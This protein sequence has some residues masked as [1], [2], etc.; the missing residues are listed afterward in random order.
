MDVR[1]ELHDAA[2]TARQA[3]RRAAPWVEALARFGYAA[4]GVVYI[5]VG[6][7]AARAALGDGDAQGSRGALASLRDEPFGQAMLWLIGLGLLGY[8]V[9]RAVAA[10]RNPENDG[11]GK[12][13]FHAVSALAYAA[14]AV[15][16]LRVASDSGGGGD[17]NWTATLM[18]APFGRFLV[19]VAG[20]LIAGYGIQQLWRAWTVD[21]DDRLDL[22]RMSAAWRVPVVRLGR[23]G[24]AARGV[25]F[26]LLGYLIV[27]SAADADPADAN[28]VEG[29]LDS[30]RDRPWLLGVVAL[31]LAAYGV[32]SLVLA[33]YRR[34]RTA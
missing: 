8:V 25:V 34:I 30:M 18:E 14:L 17:P 5:L 11:A 26:G 6:G 33:R 23:A 15:G 31:G 7:I 19:A 28:G 3:E 9:W 12:R 16:T 29:V 20:V 24:L 1:G 21:L 13:A 10:I 27:K 4:K 32:Y 22:S 2:A